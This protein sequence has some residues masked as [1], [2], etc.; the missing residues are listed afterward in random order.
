VKAKV[1]KKR[2]KLNKKMMMKGKGMMKDI[3]QLMM[4]TMKSSIK[5][6]KEDSRNKKKNFEKPRK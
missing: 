6:L 3:T 5:G 1:E 2:K 4:T